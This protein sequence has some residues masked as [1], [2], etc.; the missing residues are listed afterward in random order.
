MTDPRKE[1]FLKSCIVD[2]VVA[3]GDLWID[4]AF[5]TDA[6]TAQLWKWINEGS[7]KYSLIGNNC[8]D[9]ASRMVWKLLPKRK[10]GTKWEVDKEEVEKIT[11]RGEYEYDPQ[12]DYGH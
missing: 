2:D 3:A 12:A 1:T 11:K 5:E 6:T 7:P 10:V 4:V 8:K 9:F